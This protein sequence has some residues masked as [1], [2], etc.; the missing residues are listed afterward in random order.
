MTISFQQL[1]LQL[2][3]I[4]RMALGG[5]LIGV[6]LLG[7]YAVLGTGYWKDSGRGSE[8]EAIALQ[9]SSA[10]SLTAAGRDAIEAELRPERKLLAQWTEPFIFGHDDEL[11]TAVSRVARDTRVS[12]GSLATRPGGDTTVGVLSY[13]VMAMDVRA[14]GGTRS[15]FNFVDALSQTLPGTTIEGARF[16]GFSDRPWATLQLNFHVDPM[17]VGN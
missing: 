1:L 16:G 15:L 4:N 6:L 13:R 17:P 14:Q 5:V 10:G 12:L 11:I 9:L 3:A 2:R 7:Y 8:L